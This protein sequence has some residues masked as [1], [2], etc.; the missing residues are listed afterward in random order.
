MGAPRY[1]FGG[2]CHPAREALS[3]D[4]KT[5][6]VFAHLSGILALILGPLIVW[7]IKKDESDFVR[8]SALHALAWNVTFFVSYLAF[9]ITVVVL[10]LIYPP[11]GWLALL[12]VPA[13]FAA[14]A[15][16]IIGGMNANGGYVYEYPVAGQF[17]NRKRQR[18]RC[19]RTGRPRVGP[20]RRA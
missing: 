5:W 14:L 8:L 7:L 16:A 4:E 15:Y 6:G 20:P 2:K 19:R 13:P 17:V 18:R 11:F 10:S 12:L 1:E 3:Q 9:T